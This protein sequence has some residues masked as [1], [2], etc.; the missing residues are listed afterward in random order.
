MDGLSKQLSHNSSFRRNFRKALKSPQLV[1]G[2][3]IVVIFVFIAIF[4]PL[5]APHDPLDAVIVRRL[6]AS[7]FEYPLGT[8]NL[9][10]CVMSRLMYGAR[11]SLTVGILATAMG[12]L[13]GVFFGLIS[14]YYGGIVD[15][16]IMRVADVLMAFPGILLALGIVAILGRSTANVIIAVAIFAVPGYARIVRGSTLTVRKLEYIDA[17]RALGAR[18]GRIIFR[19]VLPNILSP[20][21]V[22]STLNVGTAVVAAAA[23]AFLGVGTPPPTPEWGIMLSGGREF[24]GVAPRLVMLPGLM[25]F[26]LVVGINLFGNGLRDILE[27]KNRS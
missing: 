17:I 14:G 23:L 5:L 7:S 20:I 3:V 16:L 9:G 13:I 21:I 25:I 6:E 26:L 12:A 18:D 10:R 22:Q 24:L 2:L 19:H 4:A 15:T 1:V 8:D 27:P 11:I